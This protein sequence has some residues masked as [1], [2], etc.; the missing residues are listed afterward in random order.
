MQNDLYRKYH[1]LAC[2][3]RD[4]TSSPFWPAYLR[5][6]NRTH[7]GWRYLSDDEHRL[8]LEL[9]DSKDPTERLKGRGYQAGFNQQNPV[10][11]AT[12][13]KELSE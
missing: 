5:G 7:F 13:E 9:C 3:L 4:L 12:F 8:W 10:D 11:L 2:Q 1:E 6:L